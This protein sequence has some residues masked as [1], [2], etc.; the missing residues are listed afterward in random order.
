MNKFIKYILGL[1]LAV[2]FHGCTDFVEPAIPYSDFDTGV[3]LRTLSATPNFNFFQLGSAKFTL[4]VEAVDIEDGKTVEKVDVL[5]RRRR[6][7]TLSPE[8]Q[9]KTVPASEFKPHTIIDPIVHESTG[10]KY[11]AA[12]IEI[13]VAEALQRMNLTAADIAGGD[14]LEFRLILTDK[15]GRTFT[16]SNLSPDIAGGQYYRSPF[17]YRVPFVCPSELAGTFDYVQTDMFCDGQITGSV[18]WTQVAG[19]TTYTSSDF[20]FGSW[21]HCYGSGTA[22][23]TLRISDA[24]NQISVTGQDQFG[25]RYTYTIDKVEGTKL[26]IKWRNTYNEFGTVVLTRRDGKNWPALRN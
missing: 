3:Y 4:V 12:T 11:P 25:D 9:V 22:G 18:T 19:T 1:L 13:T 23:G 5:V 6:G 16:N 7:Q 26:T 21:V 10:S 15:K 8:V 24:C 2:S 20:S 17:F 14:F